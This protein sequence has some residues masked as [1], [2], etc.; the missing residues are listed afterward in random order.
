MKKVRLFVIGCTGSVGR[1]VLSVCRSFPDLFEVRALAARSSAKDILALAKEFGSDRIVLTNSKGADEAR[2]QASG[3]LSILSGEK[4]LEAVA[5]GPDIDHVVAASSGTGAIRALM[6]ALERGKDVSLANKESVVV[7]G[8]WVLPLVTRKG[9]LR[10]LDSEHNAIWQC[11]EGREASQVSRVILTASGG[12][13]RIFTASQLEK[14]TPSMAVNHPV[15][16]MGAKISVDSA[17]LMNKGI[18]ILEAM[19][20]FSLPPDKVEAVLCPDSF[21]H[22]IVEFTDGTFLMSAFSP[23]MRFPCA[24][25]LF[26]PKRS[27]FPPASSASLS[28]RN[29]S[30]H[31]PDEK[32]FPALRL[33]KEAAKAGGPFPALLI[34][35]DEVA[36]E[37]FL[38]GK[39]PFTAIPQV[40]ESVFETWN[41]PAPKNLEEGLAVLDQGRKSA[42]GICERIGRRPK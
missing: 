11:L 32:L 13:F 28:G 7:A 36:V 41:G 1:S 14:V 34:G 16:P 38:V 10:P 4:A 12:P 26:Y 18:E 40:V 33:A 5:A 8:P 17:T 37:Q 42:L 23:D 35:A 20:L 21:V 6:A 15:W 2:S 25:A 24:S 3:S 30:F 19:A 39:I 9:Q 29:I 27:P 22:G 31:E